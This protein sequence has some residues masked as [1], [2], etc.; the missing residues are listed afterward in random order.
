MCG[1]FCVI[2]AVFVLISDCR[3]NVF[4][5]KPEVAV[6]VSGVAAFC[7]D[8]GHFYLRWQVS[9]DKLILI[10]LVFFAFLFC[11]LCAAFASRQWVFC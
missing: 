4:F 9:L 5:F 6:A 3:S 11:I 8:A 2:L 7:A 10:C 1:S